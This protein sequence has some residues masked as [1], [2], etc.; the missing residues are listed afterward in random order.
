MPTIRHYQ[1][2]CKI[3][4]KLIWHYAFSKSIFVSDSADNYQHY[5]AGQPAVMVPE[6]ITA[7]VEALM[8]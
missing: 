2:N 1:I 6:S 4:T 3:I 7:R 8:Y 5:G